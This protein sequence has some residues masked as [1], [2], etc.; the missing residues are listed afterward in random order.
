MSHQLTIELPADI[1]LQEAKFLLAAK[2]F[3]TGRLSLGQAA[4]LSAYSK[5]TFMELLGKTGIPVFDYPAEDLE[6]EMHL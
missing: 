4:E 6:Q 2:L 3:E 5:S 1:T